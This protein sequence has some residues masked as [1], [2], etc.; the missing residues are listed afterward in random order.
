L[1]LQREQ[2]R[3]AAIVA[4]DVAGF[5]RLVGHDEEGTLR[6]LRSHRS[7][8]IDTLIEEYGGRIAN[9]AG[10]SLLVEFP[11][12][13]DAVRCSIE[14]QKGM[15]ERNVEVE[16]DKNIWLR[17]GINVGDVVAQGND[18]LGDG[19]NVAARLEGLAEPGGVAVSGNVIEYVRDKLTADFKDGGTRTVKNIERPISIWFWQ[20][21]DM[22][23]AKII[24]TSVSSDITNQATSGNAEIH[25]EI[26]YCTS[27]DGTP[28][29]YAVAGRGPPL[30]KA[31][32]FFSHLEHE[33][34]SPIFAQFYREMA[35]NYQLVRQDQR[36]NGLSDRNPTDISFECF[37]QDFGAVADA[38]G[39]ERFP[40]YALSQGA[41][42]AVSYAVRY[43]ERVS[44]L[45]LHGGYV[46]GRLKRGM[47]NDDARAKFEAL[48]TLIRT[49]WGQDNPAFR[50][51]FT[52]MF[53]PSATVEQMNS[54]DELMHIATDPEVAAQIFRVNAEVDV[55]DII[56][57]VKAPTLV[58]HSRQDA[59][60]PFEEGQR[61]ASLIPN[62]K[63]IELDSPNHIIHHKEPEMQHLVFEINKFIAEHPV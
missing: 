52:S 46:R 49:G 42:V 33:W 15:V 24:T 21:D 7:E 25:Q 5:S 2:R 51:M 45:I 16:T 23:H 35:K 56:H 59:V 50:H 11:S 27:T 12:A 41:A 9:T 63:L 37:I 38:T 40:I 32:H 3:L 1:I 22:P 10:D 61:L 26:H 53:I 60:S 28:L 8:L 31:Q 48:T 18:L 4:A 55:G 57:Q 44:A 20:N 62:A 14:I 19:V 36:G 34:E 58:L 13:V 43:P 39:I 54:F 6:S 47:I 29:A 17:I 30:F